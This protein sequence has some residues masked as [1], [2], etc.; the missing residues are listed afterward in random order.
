VTPRRLPGGAAAA[1]AAAALEMVRA[2][3]ALGLAG[4]RAPAAAAR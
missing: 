2:R 1:A 3:P 4:G